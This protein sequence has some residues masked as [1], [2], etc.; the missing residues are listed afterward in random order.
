MG[1]VLKMIKMSEQLSFKLP[2]KVARERDAFFVSE[3]NKNA[4]ATLEDP[5]TWPQGK[6]IL[7][8]P[9]ACGKSH[10]LEIW[11]SENKAQKID[12]L[13]DF[14]QPNAGANIIVDNLQKLAGIS[15]AETRLFHLHNHLQFTGGKLLMASNMAVRQAGFGLPDLLS[16][17]EGTSCAKIDRPDDALLHAVLLKAFMDRQLSPPPA[18]LAYIVKNIDRSFDAVSNIVAQLDVQSMSI[19]RPITRAMAASILA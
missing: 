1:S 16:R 14:H 2:I 10:L 15:P 9:K 13:R 19:G 4:V 5:E 17:L 8:G 3:A 6:M 7:L 12:P 18:V 11:L